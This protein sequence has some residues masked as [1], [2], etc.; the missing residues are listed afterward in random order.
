MRPSSKT[1][2]VWK[3]DFFYLFFFFIDFF[4]LD[5]VISD[6]SSQATHMSDLWLSCTSGPDLQACVQE[7]C[8]PSVVLRLH[9]GDRKGIDAPLEK[10]GMSWYIPD[11]LVR[12]ESGPIF[13]PSHAVRMW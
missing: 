2:T 9:P 12:G 6:E 3:L 5:N 11:G 1:M 4:F 13:S 10:G 8:A 7:T